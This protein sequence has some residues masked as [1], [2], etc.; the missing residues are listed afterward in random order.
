VS[1]LKKGRA[2]IIVFIICIL[3]ITWYKN[4]N[5]KK[6]IQGLNR[7]LNIYEEKIQQDKDLYELR[8]ILDSEL[9]FIL[10]SLVKGEFALAKEHFSENIRV[11]DRKIIS[12]LNGAENEFLVPDRIMNLRQR[13]YWLEDGK[14]RSIYEIFDS[15][16]TRVESIM[17]GYIH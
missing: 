12:E 8:N 1:I 9:H 6:E 3:A 15:G 17:I 2:F 4:E 10:A 14:Y 5:H 13:A 11:S 7:K 16:Y